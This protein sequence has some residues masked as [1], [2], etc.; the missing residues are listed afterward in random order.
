MLRLTMNFV[1]RYYRIISGKKKKTLHLL[2]IIEKWISIA[3]LCLI[4]LRPK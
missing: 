1:H 3:S 2:Y 4:I